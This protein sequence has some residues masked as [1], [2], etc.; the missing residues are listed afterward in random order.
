[1]VDA[2]SIQFGS[3]IPIIRNEAKRV[4]Y[5]LPPFCLYGHDFFK[6]LTPLLSGHNFSQIPRR[7]IRK[8]RQ[9]RP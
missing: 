7:F 8:H 9:S 2:K 1:M 5:Y 4:G 3:V 6:G